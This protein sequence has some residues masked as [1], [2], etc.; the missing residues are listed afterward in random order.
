MSKKWIIV[1]ASL[2]LVGCIIFGG[3]MTALKWDFSKLSTAKY[4]NNQYNITAAFKDIAIITE[5]SD[6]EFKYSEDKSVKVICYESAKIRHTVGVMDNVLSIKYNDTRKWYDYISLNFKM[7][8]ITIY[9]PKGEYGVLS[10]KSSTGDIEIPSGYNFESI[11]VSQST[12]D[13]SCE[14]SARGDIKLKTTT[15]DIEVEN[16]TIG[17]LSLAVTTGD[18]E[19]SDVE[20]TGDIIIDVTTGEAD[21]VNTRCND[22]ISSGSTGDIMLKSVVAD[23]TINIKRSTGDIKFD[24]CDASE[25]I[26]E[27]STGDVSGTLLSDKVFITKTDTGSIKVPESVNGGKCKITT[28]TGNIKIEVKK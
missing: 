7:P 13:I 6:I 9:L 5:T 19:V 12:G 2:I 22:V 28:D 15:G 25:L 24:D 11:N 14:A 23:E 10:V 3:F 18:I 21:I 8:K 4:E 1:A 16:A 26:I 27:T 17:S 20:A